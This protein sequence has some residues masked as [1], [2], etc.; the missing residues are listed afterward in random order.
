MG[1]FADKDLDN[2][3]LEERARDT[4]RFLDEHPSA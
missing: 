4:V 3:S 2:R 1:D